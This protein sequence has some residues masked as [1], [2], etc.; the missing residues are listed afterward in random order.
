M[1]I[2]RQEATD[3]GFVIDDC[4]YPPFAYK[5]PRFAPSKFYS[6]YTPLEGKL[7]TA[8]SGMYTILQAVEK[9]SE[10]HKHE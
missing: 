10:E 2:H 5:G 4:C 7:L 6:T 9:A 8:L 1:R 3:Q